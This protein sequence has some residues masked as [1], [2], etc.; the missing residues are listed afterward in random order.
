[1]S[2]YGCG[3][4]AGAVVV[5]DGGVLGEPGLIGFIGLIGLIGP[6][7]HRAIGPIGGGPPRWKT[8]M[9]LP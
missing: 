2:N 4:G 7:G 6:P 5:D 3:A 1:L 9:P 8:W